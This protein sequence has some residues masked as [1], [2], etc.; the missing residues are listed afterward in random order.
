MS[1]ENVEKMRAAFDAFNRGDLDAAVADFSAEF[2]YVPTGALPD[3][4]TSIGDPRRSSGSCIG[5]PMSSTM[6]EWRPAN[7]STLATISSSR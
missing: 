6:L 2:E 1:Q 5:S 7:S 3:A 4:T